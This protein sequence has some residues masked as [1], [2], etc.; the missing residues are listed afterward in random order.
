MTHVA[1][2][3]PVKAS[4]SERCPNKNWR[5]LG[6]VPLATRKLLE[7]AKHAPEHW[8]LWLDTEEWRALAYVIETPELREYIDSERV[9]V[10]DRDPSYAQEWANGIHVF[11]QF[12]CA[13]PDY[14]YYGQAFVTCPFLSVQTM[15][16]M[17]EAV[18]T[19]KR[20]LCGDR[21]VNYDSALTVSRL[22]EMVW[23]DGKPVNH[24][25]NRMDGELR[26]Q[27]MGTY[28]ASHGFYVVRGDVAR[29]T[30]CR[31]GKQPLLYE[32]EGAEALKISTEEDFAR[33]EGIAV[34][35]Q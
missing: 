21:L 13:H 5:H 26:T 9:L 7:L 25:P 30:G 11:N 12:V 34:G 31:V 6:G 16:E 17:V 4:A 1:I 20:V 2:Q 24:D 28:R 22:P 15:I 18:T 35:E 32:V 10:H 19:D 29:Q 23:H 8:D 33:A 14:D 3:I 27:D